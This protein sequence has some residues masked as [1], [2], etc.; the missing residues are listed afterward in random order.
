MKKILQTSEVVLAV[1]E[2][3]ILIAIMLSNID[4]TFLNDTFSI[5]YQSRTMLKGYMNLF[6][7]INSYLLGINTIAL[8][9]LF[10]YEKKKKGKE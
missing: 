8:L 7:T 4:G 9:I 6:V 5:A 2:I 3:I 10:V 1:L